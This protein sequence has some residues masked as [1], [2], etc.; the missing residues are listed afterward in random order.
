MSGL[1]FADGSASSVSVAVRNA[2]G[3]WGNAS[4]DPM[5]DGYIF[6]NNGSNI[7][8]GNSQIV[9]N[10]DAHALVA[11]LTSLRRATSPPTTAQNQTNP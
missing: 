10:R 9:P 11:Y 5:Y 6:A 4:G 8:V 3:V 7:V 2:P 1:K